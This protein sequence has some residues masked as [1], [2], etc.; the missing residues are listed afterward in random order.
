MAAPIVLGSRR[1]PLGRF[2]CVANGLV[3]GWF[4]VVA[5]TT[6]GSRR[7]PLGRLACMANGPGHRLVLR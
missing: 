7:L 5:P 2:D 1:L 4:P 3:I 6:V